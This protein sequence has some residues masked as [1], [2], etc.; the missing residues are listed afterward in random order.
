[1]PGLPQCHCKTPGNDPEEMVLG[2]LS[3]SSTQSRH[4][5]CWGVKSLSRALLRPCC[6]PGLLPTVTG[7]GIPGVPN[8]GY[9]RHAKKKMTPTPSIGNNMVPSI[10][11]SLLGL[12]TPFEAQMGKLVPAPNMGHKGFEIVTAVVGLCCAAVTSLLCLGMSW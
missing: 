5:I 3:V 10:P 9:R 12:P 8:P 4:C 1:M 2:S 11:P 6:S 7:G